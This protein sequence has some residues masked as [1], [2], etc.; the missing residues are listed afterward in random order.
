VFRG[1]AVTAV[2]CGVALI[3]GCA[4]LQQ[5]AA[6][7]VVTAF[8]AGDPATRCALLAPA[9]LAAVE[10]AASATC[11]QVVAG[12]APRGGRVVHTSVW[13]DAAQVQ[14]ADDTLFLTRTS[15][16]WR[17]AAAGCAPNGDAPY[18]CGVNGP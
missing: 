13:G 6:E 2:G 4:A 17:I 15:A 1:I 9:T 5:P 14:T 10:R 11:T 7:Q 16:G 3:A 8:A 12:L 18:T